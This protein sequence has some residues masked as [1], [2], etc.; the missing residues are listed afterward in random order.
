MVYSTASDLEEALG[1]VTYYGIFDRDGDAALSAA[2]LAVVTE[3]L[4]KANDRIT[5][6]NPNLTSAQ[7]TR[8][9]TAIAAYLSFNYGS[10]MRPGI[11]I[12]DYEFW[13]NQVRYRQQITA[14]VPRVP[15]D[16]ATTTWRDNQEI[17]FGD[18]RSESS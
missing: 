18:T 7:L 16:E 14:G 15:S 12:D 9:E 5:P 1:T 4:S 3:V 6:Y 2:E 8:A 13:I 10:H 17:D 11:V